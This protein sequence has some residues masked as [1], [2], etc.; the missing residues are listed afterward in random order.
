VR[1]DVNDHCYVMCCRVCLVVRDPLDSFG[2]LVD[3]RR[4][5]DAQN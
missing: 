4:R 3:A 2:R 5:D 1:D